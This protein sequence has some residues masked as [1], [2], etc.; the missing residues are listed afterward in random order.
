MMGGS[1][2]GGAQTPLPFDPK[3]DYD[4]IVIG[5]GTGGLSCA[6]EARALG[7]KVAIF[8]YVSASP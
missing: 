3:A 7:L 4:L 1:S 5:G 6:Q 8:D 2:F